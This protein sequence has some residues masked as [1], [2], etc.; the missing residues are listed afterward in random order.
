V[1]FTDL[2]LLAI[3][4]IS[5]IITIVRN[6]VITVPYSAI[7]LNLKWYTFYKDVLISC[8]CCLING[9]FC[10]IFQFLIVPTTW[11]KMIIS[12]FCAC[13][14]SLISLFVILLSKSEKQNLLNKFRR[15]KNG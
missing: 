10:S 6:L 5:A 15:K 4:A 8:L 9:V 7:I 12:V 11:L 14:L 3:A 13:I 2:G 1:N